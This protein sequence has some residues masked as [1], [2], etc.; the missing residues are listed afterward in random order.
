MKRI[1]SHYERLQRHMHNVQSFFTKCTLNVSSVLVVYFY[2]L[3]GY[4]GEGGLEDAF[5]PGQLFYNMTQSFY[6]NT[7]CNSIRTTEF[8]LSCL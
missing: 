5:R 6:L 7:Q 8:T 2:E 3:G 4:E 1:Y